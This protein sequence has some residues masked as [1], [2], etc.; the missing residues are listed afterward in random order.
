MKYQYLLI[1]I[2]FFQI[3]NTQAQIFEDSIFIDSKILNDKREIKILL[4]YEY[5]V[6]NKYPVIY[7]TDAKYNFEIASSYIT[8]LIKFNSIPKTI[9]VGITQKNR[10]NELDIFWNDNG[11]K[12]KDFIF[13]EL[14]TYINNEYSTSGFNAI[15]GH[16][17]GAEF[18]HLLMLKKN[19][20]FRGFI[21]ISENLNNDVS[22]DIS[23][24]FKT[25]NGK[26]L[27]YFISSAKY[28]SPD[29]IEA[30]KS[31]EELYY[32][33][34]NT[35]I[36]F[37]NK[38]YSADHQSVLSRSL[39]D[40]ISYV[41]QDY[42]DLSQYKDYK[43]YVIN[44]KNIIEDNYGFIPS[45]NENDIDYFFGEILDNKDVEMYEYIVEYVT[46]NEISQILA[47]DRSWHYFWMDQHPKSIEYWNKTIENF[48]GTS[49]RVFYY[50]FKKAIDSYL[51]LNN[52]IGAIEF[53]EK[54]IK[55]LPQYNLSFSYFIAKIALENNVKNKT[56]SKYL[57]YCEQNYSE[58]RYFK[59]E[60]LVKLKEK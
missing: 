12:F 21:N 41:F 52:P 53:L 58:N 49:P 19:N 24:Y 10:G 22:E 2:L 17:D 59:R 35:N 33:H 37:Q 15:I 23:E 28:D 20:P 38:L 13:S 3:V 18:N 40:G 31:I 43:E 32:N 4:P 34:K 5:S 45:E 50:N 7:I 56:G 60:D 26:K 27:Y 25:Y 6:K 46:E 11:I 39:I 47:Y 36:I 16:S 54:C 44:Y 8:Q 48:E 55:R 14:I 29:R 57:K 42:R 1:T 51:I 9:L 30:G